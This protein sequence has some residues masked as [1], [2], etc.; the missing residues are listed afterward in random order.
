MEETKQMP[1]ALRAC[2]ELAG[3]FLLCF[4][5]YAFSTWGS[6]VFGINI[7]FFALATG[8]AYAVVTAIF[9]R[10]SG[11]QLNPAITVA[12]VLSSKTR[13]VDG[14]LYVVAQVLGAVAAG[15]AVV[16]LLPTSE[17]VTAKVWLTPAV[18]GFEK[19]SVA[20]SVLSQYGITF[21]VTLAIVIEV[22]ASLI[23]VSAAM[24]TLGEHGESSDRHATTMGLAYGLAAAM[25]YT[26]TG[27]GLNPAR[28]TGIALAAM[29][30]GLD[31][32]PVQQLWVFWISPILAAAVVSLAMIIA[33]MAT[34]AK[35]NATNKAAYAEVS[36]DTVRVNSEETEDGVFFDQA[37]AQDDA[38][39]D[40]KAVE[41]TE[42][43]EVR[44]QQASSQSHADEGVK[45]D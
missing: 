12:A 16:K 1:L 20:Y 29:N 40:Q 3:S 28:S 8:L 23:V 38:R 24:A 13:A 9:S 35:P 22:V 41:Q 6:A 37:A 11:G 27:A 19:G 34:T 18:N 2:A 33:Q 5:V 10:I 17:Q 4:A 45:R 14:L 25:S 21:S 36:E 7:V 39:S 43:T 31:Q 30:Q 32:N 26:V 42:E 44:D 15:F